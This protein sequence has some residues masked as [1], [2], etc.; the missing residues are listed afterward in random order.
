MGWSSLGG[1]AAKAVTWWTDGHI[2]V[3]AAPHTGSTSLYDA[4]TRYGWT[5]EPIGDH[6]GGPRTT[7]CLVRD[8]M[9]RWKSAVAHYL[10]HRGYSLDELAAYLSITTTNFVP[11]NLMPQT[12]FYDVGTPRWYTRWEGMEVIFPGMGHRNRHDDVLVDRAQKVWWAM[13]AE[14]R[15]LWRRMFAF[16]APLAGQA[17]HASEVKLRLEAVE[18]MERIEVE[19]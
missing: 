14:D 10:Q 1:D 13:P 11:V 8:P 5:H 6:E 16:D 19:G 4:A 2:A 12:W 18:W 7:F 9:Q 17:L 3:M 15:A